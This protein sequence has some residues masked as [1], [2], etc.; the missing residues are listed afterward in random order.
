MRKPGSIDQDVKKPSGSILNL[1]FNVD[2]TAFKLLLIQWLVYCH[3]AFQ[4][5]ENRFFQDLIKM[6]NHRLADLIP[7]RNTIRGWVMEEFLRRKKLL[8]EDLQAARSNIHISF[9]LWTSPNCHAIIAIC[10]HYIDRTGSRQT[11]LIAL[12]KVEGEHSGANMAATISKVFREYKIGRRIGFFVLDNA[13]TNDTCVD[14]ILRTLYPKM[15]EKQRRRRRLRC[16]GHIV[17]LA[18]QVFLLGKGAE[19]TLDELEIAFL[20][21]DF[22]KIADIW[23][24]QGALGRLHNI[25]RYI[26]MTPQRRQEFRRCVVQEDGI[27]WSIFNALEVSCLYYLQS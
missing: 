23:R 13:S 20:R 15:S 27:G 2:F 8:R 18:A 22:Q 12:R 1:I 16:L 11:K 25:V 26:R 3:V 21:Q 7:S 24:K 4:Q 19:K 17:N 5:I 9:D 14:I 10:A 6:L